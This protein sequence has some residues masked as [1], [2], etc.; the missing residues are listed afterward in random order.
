[1]TGHV[2]K[3][4]D[5]LIET[6]QKIFHL[7]K[8]S[9]LN[10]IALNASKY[11]HLGTTLE[12]LH[13]LCSDHTLAREV[14]FK[15]D[16][17]N[18]SDRL[19]DSISQ[20]SVSQSQIEGVVM[21]SSL[22]ESSV[23]SCNAVVEYSRFSVPINVS[24]KS[25]VSNCSV[26]DCELF[27]KFEIPDDTF[28]HTIP[29]FYDGSTKYVTAVFDIRDDLKKKSSKE[30]I[31]DLKLFGMAF[32]KVASRF[33]LDPFAEIFT[34]R[35]KPYSLWFAN[36]FPAVDS[37]TE[38]F[39]LAIKMIEIL[40]SDDYVE[41]SLKEYPKFSMSQSIEKKDIATMLNYRNDLYHLIT[42]KD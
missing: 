42:E 27:D 39:I 24:T 16:I 12:Y 6:R 29:I 38:S 18:R 25:I 34:D 1:M 10:I 2:S 8:G 17:F 23:V 19:K 37:M 9:Q 13:Y 26:H 28:I 31:E 4:E 33:C 15:R 22:L 5:S 41:L 21:H 20:D 35:G 3:V 36:I 11:I 32:D 7:L 30:S 14:G 40:K